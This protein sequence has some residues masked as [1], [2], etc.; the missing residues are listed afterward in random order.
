MRRKY[1]R[2]KLAIFEHALTEQIFLL[3]LAAGSVHSDGWQSTAASAL[4][5]MLPDQHD[6]TSG[7]PDGWTDGQ[8]DGHR[9]K[10]MGNAVTVNVAQVVGQFIMDA[11]QDRT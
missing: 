2:Q 7:F 3:V 6:F 4:N 5:S 8:T 10:Q 11:E 9:Y 1:F